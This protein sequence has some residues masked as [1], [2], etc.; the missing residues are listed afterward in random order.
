[1]FKTFKDMTKVIFIYNFV[2]GKGFKNKTKLAT[3]KFTCLIVSY[4]YV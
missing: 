4:G 2:I 3:N 1:M